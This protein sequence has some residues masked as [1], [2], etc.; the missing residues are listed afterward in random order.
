MGGGKK[1]GTLIETLFI[2]ILPNGE[3]WK[4]RSVTAG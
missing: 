1:S 4:D 2:V 3:L